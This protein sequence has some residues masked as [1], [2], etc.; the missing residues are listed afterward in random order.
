[1]AT[2]PAPAAAVQSAA[3][4]P[5]RPDPGTL[6]ALRCPMCEGPVYQPA[7]GQLTCPACASAPVPAVG[8]DEPIPG[9]ACPQCGGGLRGLFRG[10]FL[11][12]GPYCPAC[13]IP[14]TPSEESP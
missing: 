14:F 7:P 13:P 6:T 3:P 9:L 12:D 1:M 10:V 2:L 8:R 4:P 5:V 11:A